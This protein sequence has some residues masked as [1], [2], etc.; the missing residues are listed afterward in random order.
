[1]KIIFR[2]YENTD[3]PA[4]PQSFD[5]AGL[6]GSLRICTSSEFPEDVPVAGWGLSF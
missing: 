6:R 3:Y 4:Y 1:M 5:S 2:F